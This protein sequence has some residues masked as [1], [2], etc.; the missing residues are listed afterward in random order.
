[1]AARIRLRRTGAHKKPN[2]RFVVA[3][4]HA[5]RDGRFIETLGYYNP[6]TD[7]ATIHVNE[8]RTLHWLG[9]GALPSET[10]GSLLRK[11]GIMDK[12]KA[13]K[14]GEAPAV[15]AEAASSDTESAT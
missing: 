15:E 8:A 9:V 11:I 5:P 12:F 13:A 3:D 6:L 10:A 4:Q 7:P 1:M 2:Y 14:S